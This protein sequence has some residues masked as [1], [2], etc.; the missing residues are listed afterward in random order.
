MN[1]AGLNEPRLS[2]RGVTP[3]PA[4]A[5]SNGGRIVQHLNLYFE[6]HEKSV[7]DREINE[8]LANKY[9]CETYTYLRN[10][11]GSVTFAR[12]Q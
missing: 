8:T 12:T 1:S 2:Y 5:P 6:N 7:S 10:C 11:E 4:S 3:P 9:V